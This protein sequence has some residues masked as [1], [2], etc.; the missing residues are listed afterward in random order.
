[1]KTIGVFTHLEISDIETMCAIT[2]KDLP[3]TFDMT[4]LKGTDNNCFLLKQNG[5][6]RS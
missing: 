3:K 6:F 2:S 5:K 1:M 4:M